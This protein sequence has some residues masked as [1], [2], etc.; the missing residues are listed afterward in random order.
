MTERFQTYI[1]EGLV[2]KESVDVGEAESLMRRAEERLAYI[3]VQ[4][5]TERTASFVF[6]DIYECMREAV[7]ALMAMN[8]CKP[9]SH[10]AIVAYLAEFHKFP[11]SDV[12]TFDRC[13]ILR[14]KAIYRAEKVSLETS[15]ESLAFLKAFL[16][17]LKQEFIKMKRGS[18]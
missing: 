2:K 17:K 16:P 3:L 14:N 6:E 1:D 11:E 8:G 7:Q 9:F 12:R 5:L 10:E 15:Q 4:P 18:T 13:R